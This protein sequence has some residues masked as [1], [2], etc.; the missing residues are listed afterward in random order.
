MVF[1]KFRHKKIQKSVVSL[2]YQ[3]GFENSYIQEISINDN[4]VKIVIDLSVKKEVDELVLILPNLMQE[5]KGVDYRYK[6]KG[7]RVYIEIGKRELENIEFNESYLGE[8]LVVKFPTSFGYTE[9]DFSDGASCH[10]LNGGTT[11]M[12]KTYFLLYLCTVLYLQTN[13]KMK[14]YITSSK[15]KDYYSFINIPNVT[16]S[17]THNEL[18]LILKELLQEYKYRDGLLNSPQLLKAT[19]AKDVRKK[20]PEMYSLFRPIFVVIDEYARF[21]DSKEIQRMVTELVETA[22]FVNIHVIIS[23]QR[24]DAKTVLNARIKGN[25]LC[26]VCFTTADEANS[27]IILDSKGAEKLG[28]KPGRAILQN[29]DRDII[30]V[31]KMDNETS[32]ELL[33]K[34]RKGD[35]NEEEGKRFNDT[36]L[37]NKV[38]SLFEESI[39]DIDI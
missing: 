33:N 21:S 32:F 34:Y 31:P 14:L 7:K 17:K 36:E 28:K 4:I 38:Q 5:F 16:L 11:R 39:N 13:G 23:S 35:I 30:Q 12:G 1:L 24:P 6:S 19:D 2:L 26:R 3:K 29:T 37:S 20:Y 22:G 15:I 8:N 18:V 25:L 10:L 27:M 9:I